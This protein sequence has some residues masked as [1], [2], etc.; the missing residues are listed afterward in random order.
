MVAKIADQYWDLYQF[1][2]HLHGLL[3]HLGSLLLSHLQLL[4]I[5]DDLVLLN[6]GKRPWLWTLKL[7]R[8]HSSNCT[9]TNRNSFL[10]LRLPAKRNEPVRDIVFDRVRAN[11]VQKHPQSNSS[12]SH[13]R[14]QRGNQQGNRSCYEHWR[15][16]NRARENPILQLCSSETFLEGPKQTIWR[17]LVHP[18]ERTSRK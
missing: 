18:R 9:N 17:F 5:R 6:L 14:K 2:L 7:I 15:K 1:A 4:G 16:R 12:G 11:P 3:S 8:E 13:H 10:F